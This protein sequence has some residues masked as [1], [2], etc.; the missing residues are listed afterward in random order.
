MSITTQQRVLG[1]VGSPR[2]NGNTEMLVDA[3]LEGAEE[4]GDI[5]EKGM[6]IDQNIAPCQACEYC[7]RAGRCKQQDDMHG[8]LQKMRQSDLWVLGTPVYWRGPSAQFKTFMDRWFGQGSVVNF[9]GKRAILTIPSNS[10]ESLTKP[11]IN[12]FK[13]SFAHLKM[14]LVDVVIA[15][16]MWEPGKVNE[17]PD[18]LEAARHAGLRAIA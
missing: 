10:E 17:H 5:V 16:N 3:V 4:G 8:L 15:P 1:V 11:L 14:E 12:M 9:E 6:L 13:G 7:F 18:I 2:R